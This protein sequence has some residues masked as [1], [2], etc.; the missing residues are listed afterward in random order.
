[1][2]GYLLFLLI[3]YGT[4][5]EAAHSHGAVSPDPPAVAAMSDA[6]GSQSSDT[7]HSH[8]TECSIC[9]FQEQ[10][11]EGLVHAPL[12]TRTPLAELAF[13]FTPTV[14][15]PSTSTTSPSGRAPPLVWA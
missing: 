7:G 6:G 4:T 5:A 12:F 3:L 1:V 10:L 14:F 8:H 2:V 15:Y 11:F 13:V 9:Q